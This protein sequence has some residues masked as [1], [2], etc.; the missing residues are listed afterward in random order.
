MNLKWC[1]LNSFNEA[2][3]YKTTGWIANNYL[4][5]FRSGLCS[6]SK[7]NNDPQPL[8]EYTKLFLSCVDKFEES[9]YVPNGAIPIWKTRG[10]FLSFLNL[11]HN[12]DIL[13]MFVIFGKE[14][15]HDIYRV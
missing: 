10:N 13:A 5:F 3:Y 7:H 4:A 2:K 14:N 15:V 11:P 8:Q 12:K 6:L 9:V 1:C